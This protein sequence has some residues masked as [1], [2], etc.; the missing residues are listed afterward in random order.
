MSD[1]IEFLRVAEVPACPWSVGGDD[2]GEDALYKWDVG[3][4]GRL[5][6]VIS[7]RHH[8]KAIAAQ[9][10]HI[11]KIAVSSGTYSQVSGIESTLQAQPTPT[12]TIEHVQAPTQEPLMLALGAVEAP[13]EESEEESEDE[14]E[15]PAPAKKQEE[16]TSLPPGYD[17]NDP[18]V[19]KATHWFCA[20]EINGRVC[21]C[22]ILRSNKNNEAKKHGLPSYRL[23]L[24][25]EGHLKCERADHKAAGCQATFTSLAGRSTHYSRTE[26]MPLS[27]SHQPPM[28]EVP[29]QRPATEDAARTTAEHRP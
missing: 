11:S 23:R 6:T 5:Y 20:T 19:L 7:C 13:E 4:M 15:E 2:C 22:W 21:G 9:F 26:L 3:Y 12:I 27:V 16:Q 18:R 8:A 29:F 24:L 25:P 1:D 14:A 10:A 28:G 17:P